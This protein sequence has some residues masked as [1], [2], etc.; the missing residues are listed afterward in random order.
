MI[1]QPNLLGFFP[2]QCNWTTL[3]QLVF[4]SGLPQQ[5]AVFLGVCFTG[6][7]SLLFFLPLADH[8]T[9]G[10]V[11]MAMLLGASV[12][13]GVFNYCAACSMFGLG[14]WLGLLPKTVHCAAINTK[15][16]SSPTPK[17]K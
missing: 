2:S 7:A 9:A 14:I 12:L 11:V 6:L 4:A 13:Y 8:S 1:I 5:T 15:A 10:C 3:S 17:Q 16:R